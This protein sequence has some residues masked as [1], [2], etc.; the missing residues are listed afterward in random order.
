MLFVE[1]RETWTTPRGS[2]AFDVDKPAPAEQRM[3]WLAALGEDHA[4]EAAALAG[5]F[6]LG[7]STIARIASAATSDSAEIP[8]RDRLRVRAAQQTRLRIDALAQRIDAKATWDDIVLP[9]AE[10]TLRREIAA[11]VEGRGT[12]H[13]EWVSSMNRGLGIS[14]RCLRARAALEKR[15]RRK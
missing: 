13:D 3:L 14:A 7:S 8:L 1:T 5:Q 6:S 11:H 2:H 10:E 15:W 9:P 12:V 4:A